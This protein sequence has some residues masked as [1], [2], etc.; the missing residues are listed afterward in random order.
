STSVQAGAMVMIGMTDQ[1]WLAV[2]TMFL[3][4]AA[5]ITPANTLGVSIQMGLPD[6]ARARGMSRYQMAIMGSS[7]LGAAR[8]GQVATWTSMPVSLFLGAGA[9]LGLMVLANRLM[10]DAGLEDDLTP[11]RIFA[12][13]Q[14]QAPPPHGHVMVMI[15]YRIDPARAA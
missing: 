1:I 14:I 8:W 9:L 10:P 15:E 11:K 5:W 12:A 3:S 7:A 6:W 2:P 4:G 13:P